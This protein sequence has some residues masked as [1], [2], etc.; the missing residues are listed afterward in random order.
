MW[1]YL[2]DWL[3]DW[4]IDTVLLLLLRAVF[5]VHRTSN[6]P[7]AANPLAYDV[8]N[9]D[10]KLGFNGARSVYTVP[11]DGYYMMHMS[12]GIPAYE[13]LR[14]TLRGAPTS[15]NSLMTISK[16]NGEVTRL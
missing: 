7:L 4:L 5:S 14:Y 9:V 16:Y 13:A 6:T 1:L 15:P 10:T 3:P 2:I 8:T 11:T 12:A